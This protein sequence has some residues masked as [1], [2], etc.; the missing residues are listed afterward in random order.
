MTESPKSIQEFAQPIVQT[1]AMPL[2]ITL[3]GKYQNILQIALK[4]IVIVPRYQCNQLGAE[5]N[6]TLKGLFL[7]TLHE[8]FRCSEQEAG[9]KL[10][11]RAL[12]KSLQ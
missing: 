5:T 11:T 2:I 7:P 12:V 1:S 9:E 6:R 8:K 3:P 4:I 10:S